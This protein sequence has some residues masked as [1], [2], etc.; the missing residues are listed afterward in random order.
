MYFCCSLKSLKERH[1]SKKK[2]I[3][4]GQ[5]GIFKN[6]TTFANIVGEGIKIKEEF[7]S[8]WYQEK[9]KDYEQML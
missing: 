2:A 7:G 1:I 9:L 8:S 5:E 4:G 6:S 3:N